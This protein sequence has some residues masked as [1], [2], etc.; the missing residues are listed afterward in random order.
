MVEKV[1]VLLHLV[2][3]Q[4]NEDQGVR[5]KHASDERVW[6]VVDGHRMVVQVKRLVDIKL[7]LEDQALIF[8]FV[9][10]KQ[11]Q[12]EPTVVQVSHSKLVTF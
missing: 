4:V 7:I 2:V 1:E 11:S 10:S 12:V 6:E 3:E 9:F 5:H 8:S